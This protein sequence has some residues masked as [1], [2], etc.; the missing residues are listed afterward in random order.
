MIERHEREMG[1]SYKE[2]FRLLPIALKNIDYE[3]VD[4]LIKFQYCGGNIQIKLGVERER[5]IASLAIPVLDVVFIYTDI[6]SQDIERF[7]LQFD[8][9]YQRGGG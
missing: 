4:R 5:K 1:I 8:R 6:N 2:F 3:V 9:S 7:V